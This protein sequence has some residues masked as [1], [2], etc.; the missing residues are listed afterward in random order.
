MH[1]DECHVVV[2]LWDGQDPVN[3][4]AEPR[5]DVV[6]VS[7]GCRIAS[8]MVVEISLKTPSR[9]PGRPTACVEPSAETTIGNG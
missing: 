5:R 2:T 3:R 1:D 6:G 4:Q 8:P 7:P 9:V